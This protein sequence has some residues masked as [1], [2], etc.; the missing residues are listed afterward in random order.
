MLHQVQQAIQ[1]TVSLSDTVGNWQAICE[2]LAE[3]SRKR[4]PQ[5]AKFNLS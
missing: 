1:P 5:L 2:S 4:R 3:R